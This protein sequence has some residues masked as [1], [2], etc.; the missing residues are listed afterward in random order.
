MD[1]SEAC[2]RFYAFLNLNAIYGL[3]A[4]SPKIDNDRY[5]RLREIA[6]GKRRN[7]GNDNVNTAQR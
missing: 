4:D 3:E 7:G 2:R 6:Y 1:T 5:M